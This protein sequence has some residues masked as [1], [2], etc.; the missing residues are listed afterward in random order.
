MKG[1]GF[2]THSDCHKMYT[3][4]TQGQFDRDKQ[5]VTNCRVRVKNNVRDKESERRKETQIE[6]EKEGERE[7]RD[8]R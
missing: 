6:R 3:C 4:A 5:E 7:E 8:M 1:H 2:D